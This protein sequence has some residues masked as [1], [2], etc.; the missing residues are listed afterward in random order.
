MENIFNIP[1]YWKIY[2]KLKEEHRKDT[3]PDVL[4]IL[5]TLEEF[6]SPQQI[7]QESRNPRNKKN[8]KSKKEYNPKRENPR[9]HS[10]QDNEKG[11]KP[12][13]PYKLLHHGNYDWKDCSHNSDSNKFKGKKEIGRKKRKVKRTEELENKMMAKVCPVPKNSE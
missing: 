5:E 12:K 8:S 13:N 6:D 9:Q 2:F 3:I 11:D 10:K 1:S 4:R 7:T